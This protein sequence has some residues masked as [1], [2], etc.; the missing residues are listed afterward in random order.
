MIRKIEMKEERE[1]RET[2]NKRTISIIL[3]L[4]LLL[5]TAGYFVSEMFQEKRNTL[6][7]SGLEFRQTEHGTW[8][9]SYGGI[10]YETMYNPGEVKNISDLVSESLGKKVS[11]YYNQPLYISAEPIEELPQMAVQELLTNLGKVVS[12][13]NYACLDENCSQ[14]YPIKNCSTDNIII[15][16]KSSVNSSIIKENEKCVIIEYAEGEQEKTADAFLFK[17]MDIK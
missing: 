3:A 7:F 6:V 13:S 11:D 4:V 15:F 17:I 12:R 14:N 9:F 10:S 1:K 16:K 5:S 8:Q 2:K